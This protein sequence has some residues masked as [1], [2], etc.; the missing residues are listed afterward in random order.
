MYTVVAHGVPGGS[1]AQAFAHVE[2]ARAVAEH[3][4]KTFAAEVV[5]RRPR[6]DDPLCVYRSGKLVI[7]RCP[8][9]R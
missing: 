7:C 3:L 8:E 2:P 4:S 1:M 5:V 6:E 9:T